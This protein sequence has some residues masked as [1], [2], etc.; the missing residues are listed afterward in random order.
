MS[1]KSNANLFS[2]LALGLAIVA[3]GLYALAFLAGLFATTFLAGPFGLLIAI[4]VAI[5]AYIFVAL[6]V[7]RWQGKDS[8]PY[9]D[10]EK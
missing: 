10:L 7:Q 4:P 2:Q 8:D 9:S 1:E 6:V 5:L 3:G